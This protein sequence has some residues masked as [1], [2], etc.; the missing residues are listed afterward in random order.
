MIQKIKIALKYSWKNWKNDW[1]NLLTILLPIG[2]SLAPIFINNIILLI[3][4]EVIFIIFI[5]IG[6]IQ[7]NNHKESIDKLKLNFYK[8]EHERDHLLNSIQGIPDEIIRHLF[9]HWGLSYKERITIYRYNEDSFMP[10]GRFSVN[11]ELNKR[12]RDKYPK[13]EGFI[14]KSWTEGYYYI[15]NLPEY[16]GNEKNYINYVSEL[17]GMKKTVLKNITMKS[18]TYFCKNLLFND[19]EAIAV[20]VV[21][22]LNQKLPI[23]KDEINNDLDGFFG[24]VLV[25][26]I[27][28]NL[29]A[30]RGGE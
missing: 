23:D 8:T 15:D 7:T 25:S 3:I 27:G 1:G 9:F 17:S 26:V 14:S 28:P 20:I 24:K 4:T 18:R 21:E 16:E 10:V 29:P 22:S 30:G 2:A 11:R 12:G 13:E 19:S 5:I 6:W